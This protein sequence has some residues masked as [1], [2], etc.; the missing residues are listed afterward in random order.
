MKLYLNALGVLN[1]LGRGKHEVARNLFRGSRAGLVPRADLLP[2][3]TV[4][5]GEVAGSLP[6]VPARLAHFD[7][8]NNRLALAALTEIERNIEVLAGRI[9]PHRIAVIM[10]TSTSGIADGEAALAERISRGEWPAGYHSS[11]QEIPKGRWYF[12]GALPSAARVR[13]P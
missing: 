8:R 6:P 4:R 12:R 9:G 1:S 7:C 11:R 3:R 10:G 5:V 2:E 13:G